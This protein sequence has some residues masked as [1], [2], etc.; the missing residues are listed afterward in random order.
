MATTVKRFDL[1]AVSAY[2][3]AVEHG[4][5]GTEAEWA[6][7]QAQCGENAQA[8]AADRAA[9][10]ALVGEIEVQ[11]GEAIAAIEAKGRETLDE[12]PDDYTKLQQDVDNT[13]DEA[14]RI[15]DLCINGESR[16]Q[17]VTG[18][19][20][21]TS[22]GKVTITSNSKRA[23]VETPIRGVSGTE[24]RIVQT[25]G[26]TAGAQYSVVC[27]Y[28]TDATG[29][30]QVGGWK[31]TPIALE[32]G[33]TY[34]FSIRDGTN[35]ATGEQ[36][37]ADIAAGNVYLE[38]VALDSVAAKAQAAADNAM[39]KVTELGTDLERAEAD[40]L[41]VK[42]FVG[43]PV[44]QHIEL[45]YFASEDITTELNNASRGRTDIF[46]VPKL[47]TFAISDTTYQYHL[48]RQTVV[49]GVQTTEAITSAW[50]SG[51][52]LLP[53]SP[54][55]SYRAML[56]RADKGSMANDDL[57]SV[58]FTVTPVQKEY[59]MY[60]AEKNE[61]VRR[62]MDDVDSKTY[63]FL[64]SSDNHYNE[65]ERY[66]VCQVQYA[67]EMAEIAND[68][69]ADCIVN[70]GD[71]CASDHDDT[72]ETPDLNVNRTRMKDMVAGFI[73]KRMPFMYAIAHHELY[74]FLRMENGE[75]VYAI[76]KSIICDIGH[77][78]MNY[79]PNTIYQDGDRSKPNYYTDV[80]DRKYGRYLRM[81]FLDGVSVLAVGYSYNTIQFLKSA[82]ESV[83]A[84]YTVM[85][86]S[87]T[88]TRASAVGRQVNGGNVA[89]AGEYLPNNVAYNG[90]TVES[91]IEDFIAGGG[92]FAGFFHGHTHCD[93]VV[94]DADMNFSLISIACQMVGSADG[95]GI[96]SNE[97]L[98]CYSGRNEYYL[99]AYCFDVVCVHPDKRE[100][101]FFRFGVGEDRT[102]TY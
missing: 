9:V 41:D 83:P 7:L 20:W 29:E 40:I 63:V 62:V 64:W 45:N 25:D 85:C 69:G 58:Y 44:Y 79:R 1:G 37:A 2:A 91:L 90:E 28:L 97:N 34:Y 66:G 5:R 99:T 72:D 12:I 8:V 16:P 24:A 102:V 11:Q 74:P 96:T 23:R 46:Q 13:S 89:L 27:I 30:I 98:S 92:N 48:F 68:I 38:V 75:S 94:K 21:N 71:I 43:A 53:G 84:G 15:G 51:S 54:D 47:S 101:N 19:L 39:S 55:A 81:I 61:L 60:S 35:L 59:E 73:T 78:T 50:T 10:E 31:T 22:D 65:R 76:D 33:T 49:D 87:H 82:L 36:I 100:I 56:R 93:N 18:T 88:P 4:F 32:N 42:E 77:M 52:L 26:A 86:F 17:I 70:T 95:A 67:E 6:M 3:L 14:V 80:V 57:S